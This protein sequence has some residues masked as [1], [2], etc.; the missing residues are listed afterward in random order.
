MTWDETNEELEQIKKQFVVLHETS[1]KNWSIEQ[2]NLAR[3]LRE[4]CVMLQS[5]RYKLIGMK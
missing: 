2:K 4:R 5:I 3:H 1:E